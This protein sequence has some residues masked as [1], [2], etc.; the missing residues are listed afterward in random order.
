[1]HPSHTRCPTDARLDANAV[2]NKYSL[3]CVLVPRPDSHPQF[4]SRRTNRPFAGRARA[5]EIRSTR[6]SETLPPY[7]RARLSAARRQASPH[8]DSSARA[9]SHDVS[10]EITADAHHG[11]HRPLAINQIVP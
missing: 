6:R 10:E 5:H 3:A 1:T 2:W 9:D 4:R 7:G 8:V 11:C